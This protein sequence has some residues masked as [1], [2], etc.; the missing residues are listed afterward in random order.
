M[1]FI[2]T[3]IKTFVQIEITVPHDLLITHSTHFNLSEGWKLPPQPPSAPISTP[4][5]SLK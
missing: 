2:A 4:R 5:G 1:Y 3:D